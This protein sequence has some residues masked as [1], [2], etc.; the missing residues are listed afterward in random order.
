[1]VA[2]QALSKYAALL[3]GTNVNLVI[4]ARGQGINKKFSVTSN[5]TLLLQRQAVPVPNNLE[6]EVG[7][8]R[9]CSTSGTGWR[10]LVK[11]LVVGVCACVCMYVLW[12]ARKKLY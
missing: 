3:Y 5:N 1:M 11:N 9:L 10:I 8:R 2:L 12:H 7:G 4:R 6:F